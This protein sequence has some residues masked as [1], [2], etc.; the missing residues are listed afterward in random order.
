MLLINSNFDPEIAKF[1]IY[2]RDTRNEVFEII[3]QISTLAGI[4]TLIKA[5]KKISLNI[6]KG[7]VTD[8]R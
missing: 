7:H 8:G 4:M 2:N 1:A 3:P 6:F 5:E